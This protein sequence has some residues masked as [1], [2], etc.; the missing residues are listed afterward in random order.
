MKEINEIEK[1][2]YDNLRDVFYN[3]LII[4]ILGKGYYNM[5]MDV[6]TSDKLASEDILYEYRR[7]LKNLKFYKASFV[8]IVL[9][10]ILNLLIN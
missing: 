4:P 1:L 2:Q 5:G 7:V 6:Y 9:L 10:N 3:N 8:I